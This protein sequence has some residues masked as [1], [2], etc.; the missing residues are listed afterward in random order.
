MHHPRVY[1]LSTRHGPPKTDLRIGDIMDDWGDDAR[2]TRP[3]NHQV[4]ED[5]S[6]EDLDFYQHGFPY[7]SFTD[8]LF[9]LYPV[10][11]ENEKETGEYWVDS[12]LGC[13][14]YRLPDEWGKLSE[15][16]QSALKEG[17]QWIFETDTERKEDSGWDLWPNLL[18]IVLA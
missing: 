11:L 5:V 16:D 8:M 14:D 6:R 15:E 9:Y 3:I 4:P 12:L 1:E 13:I 2:A 7:M 10:A 17:L 18:E